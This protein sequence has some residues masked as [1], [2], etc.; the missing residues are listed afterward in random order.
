MRRILFFSHS[1]DLY[2]AER[3]LLLLLEGL[4]RERCEPLL[5]IPGEGLMEERAAELAISQGK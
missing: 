1:P 5:V 2:G 4:D 3:S